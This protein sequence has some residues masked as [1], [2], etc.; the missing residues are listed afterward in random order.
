M[1]RATLRTQADISLL[2]DTIV[3]S[4]LEAVD[5]GVYDAAEL[6]ERHAK[7]LAPVRKVAY[8]ERQAV[9]RELST[10][11]IRRGRRGSRGFSG[12]RTTVRRSQGYLS[13]PEV[14]ED[15]G[16][17][18]L[19]NRE[20]ESFLSGRGRAEL[21]RGETTGGAIFTSTRTQEFKINQRG[22]IRKYTRIVHTQ[23]LGGRLRGE[24]K[25]DVISSAAET[26]IA[27]V[28]IVSPTP[29]AI[30][31]EFPTSRTAE[32]PYM[33]PT[34]AYLRDKLVRKVAA[35]LKQRTGGTFKAA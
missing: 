20:D 1:P 2:V 4:I 28:D 12:L 24:I 26:G 29:Y 31:V 27:R 14:V 13:A 8:V 23:T 15:A 7:R 6:G 5:E 3:E 32:Q 18:R 11:E 25:I 17:Y 35:R 19:K 22:K 10:A 16:R 33:R 9:T 21:R 30:Y 34:L